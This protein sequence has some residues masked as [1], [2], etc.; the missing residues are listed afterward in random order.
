MKRFWL[1]CIFLFGFFI[2][3]AQSQTDLLFRGEQYELAAIGYEQLY[4]E[5][6][7]SDSGI[8]YLLKKAEC[9]KRLGRLDKAYKTL[10]RVSSPK[11]DTLQILVLKQK[12]ALSFLTENFQETHQHL[13][14][15]KLKGI[16]QDQELIFYEF[17]A[18]I[19]L[20]RWEEA[21]ELLYQNQGVFK[22]SNDEVESIF[23]KKMKVKNPEKAYN[24]SIFLPGI[25]QA[26][27]GYPLKGLVSGTVQTGLV[28]FSLYSLYTKY[29]FSGALVGVSL[30]YSFYLGGANYAEKL[31]ILRNQE[32]S[33]TIQIDFLELVETKKALQ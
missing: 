14:R 28:A 7:H 18:L 13:L 8:Y 23:P 12:V 29:F 25:G 27:A 9:Y 24:I 6:A 15:C 3:K 31:A 33:Q 10:T 20:T 2:S 1:I 4:Y 17:L 19:S 11:S 22:L 32:T 21:R 30:F 5:Q 26:Y 16:D